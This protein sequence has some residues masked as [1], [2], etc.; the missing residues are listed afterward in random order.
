MD[1][2][3]ADGGRYF[4][5]LVAI[6]PEGHSGRFRERRVLHRFCPGVVRI[7]LRYQVPLVPVAMTGFHLASPIIAELERDHGPNDVIPL[8]FTLPVKLRAD[9]GEPFTLDEYY[10]RALSRDEEF[11]VA[12]EVVRPRLA[13]LLS[14][15]GPVVLEPWAAVRE[16]A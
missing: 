13:E 1:P 7:A 6:Y 14:K 8:P 16:E 12:N 11:E 2:F 15:R 10:G 4:P 9:F 3:L 5:A